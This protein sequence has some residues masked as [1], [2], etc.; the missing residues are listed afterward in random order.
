MSLVESAILL[1][2]L[3]LV[4]AIAELYRLRANYRRR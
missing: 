4:G 1:H 2:L 3:Y